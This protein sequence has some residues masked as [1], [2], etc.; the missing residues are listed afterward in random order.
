M[1]DP[2]SVRFG[3]LEMHF[4]LISNFF[5]DLH[6]IGRVLGVEIRKD[7][8]I[9][10]GDRQEL[11]VAHLFHADVVRPGVG[12]HPHEVVARRVIDGTE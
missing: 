7:V 11:A 5:G 9:P 10:A 12:R 4:V 8:C 6:T 1:G 2:D 3:D